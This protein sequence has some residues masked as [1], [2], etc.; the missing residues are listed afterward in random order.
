M[1]ETFERLRRVIVEQLGCD[2]AR[3]TP[4]TRFSDLFDSMD[5]VEVVIAAEQEFGVTIHDSDSEHMSR[6]ADLVSYIEEGGYERRTL[7]LPAR[8]PAPAVEALPLPSPSPTP[9]RQPGP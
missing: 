2:P 3:V 1:S 5:D 8:P 9:N 4:E 6:V 7:P